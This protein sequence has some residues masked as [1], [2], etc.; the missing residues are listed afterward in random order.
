[1]ALLDARDEIKERLDLVQLVSR[2]VTLKRSGRNFVGLC[3]FHE[4]KTPSFTV[5]PEKQLFHCFGCGASGDIFG[6]LMKIEGLTFPEALEQLAR[7]AGVK[8]ERSP[9]ARKRYS[10]K[11][12]VLQANAAAQKEFVKQLKQGDLPAWVKRYLAERFTPETLQRFKL[13]YAPAHGKLLSGQYKNNPKALRL[14][15]TAGLVKG[16]PGDEYDTFRDRLMFPIFDVQGRVVAFGGRAGPEG[17]PKYLN[18]PETAAFS[19]SSTLYG[20][21]L[22]YKAIQ[23][24]NQAILVEGYTDV[25]AMHTAGFTNA[26]ATLGTSLADGHVRLL[27][28]YANSVVLAYDA[29]SAGIKA[30]LRGA[31]RF[32]AFDLA[33]AVATMP[34]GLDPE[35][36]LRKLGPEALKQALEQA[37]PLAL[38]ALEKAFEAHPGKDEGSQRALLGEIRRIL[39][40][41][42]NEVLRE[43]YLQQAAALWSDSPEQHPALVAALRR[44]VRAELRRRMRRDSLS[45]R[46]QAPEQSGLT[47]L[48]QARTGDLEL[49]NEVLKTALV[50]ITQARD[51]IETAKTE[52]FSGKAQRT[53]FVIFGDLLQRDDQPLEWP[54]RHEWIEDACGEDKAASQLFI[55]LSLEAEEREEVEDERRR[56]LLQDLERAYLR[57][58]AARLKAEYAATGAPELFQ[59]FQALQRKLKARD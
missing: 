22:A 15:R 32:E 13:G 19:K 24:A 2:Y 3:P 50:S 56:L 47:P 55:A 52:Y 18:S 26:V 29:D 35:E 6:F 28:R 5:S 30:A 16:P 37:R 58:E 53:L 9:E 12:Q 10:A 7:E 17:Q 38:F 41:V 14:L 54:P 40:D 39:A 25:I 46:S 21:N 51:I 45:G 59:Q 23:D 31:Q 8:L 20:L 27:R 57:R 36:V 4:E 49:E 48:T 1:M 42:R 44:E 34:E 11:Q 43:E 33:V